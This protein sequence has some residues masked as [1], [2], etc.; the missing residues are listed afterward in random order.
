MHRYRLSKEAFEAI[1][2]RRPEMAEEISA[3]LA[4]RR[5][6]L[7]SAREEASE[8]ALREKMKSTQRAFLLRMRDFFALGQQQKALRR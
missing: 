8:E 6:G 4:A 2:R 5:V 7:D 1:L 3:T